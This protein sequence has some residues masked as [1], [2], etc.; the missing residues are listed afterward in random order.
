MK[1]AGWI[2]LALFALFMLGASV[3]PKLLKLDVAR[4]PLEQ[5]AYPVK[6]LVLIGLMELFFTLLVL[7]P[8]T[9]LLGGIL[10][11]GLLGGAIASQLRA[12]MPLASHTLFGVYLGLFMWLGIALRA[13]AVLALL[14][15]RGQ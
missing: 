2:I 11:T 5:I 3:A 12:E 13:P 10:M 9:S 8:R 14:T 6:Y 1:L 15:G 7:Y 4:A